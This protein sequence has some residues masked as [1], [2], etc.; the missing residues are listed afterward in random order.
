MILTIGIYNILYSFFNDNMNEQDLIDQLKYSNPNEIFV[1]SWRNKLMVIKCPFKVVAIEDVGVIKKG[2]SVLVTKVK[3]TL[4][5]I[6][7]FIIQ[8][9]AYYYHHFEIYMK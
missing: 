6:T 3:V 2:D 8:G 4:N 9:E 1:V 7:V 5:L